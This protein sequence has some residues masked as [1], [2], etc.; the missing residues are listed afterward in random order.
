[1]SDPLK[2]RICFSLFAAVTVFWLTYR[3]DPKPRT[4]VK[5]MSP[6]YDSVLNVF[7]FPMYLA[8][9]YI[10]ICISNDFSVFIIF[11]FINIS[12]IS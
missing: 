12:R 9:F 5:N 4:R 10:S 8:I 2:Y 6:Q 1:M 7:L 11:D 3:S